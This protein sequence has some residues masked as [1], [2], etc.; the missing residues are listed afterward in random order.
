MMKDAA[1]K[2]VSVYQIDGMVSP[3]DTCTKI[4]HIG[5]MRWTWI[6]RRFAPLINETDVPAALPPA[7]T[8]TCLITLLCIFWMHTISYVF[9]TLGSFPDI[10]P[11]RAQEVYDKTNKYIYIITYIYLKSSWTI[12][13][14]NSLRGSKVY[15]LSVVYL[16]LQ[17]MPCCQ[18]LSGILPDVQSEE[19]NASQWEHVGQVEIRFDWV[20]GGQRMGASCF[21]K[22][23]QNDQHHGG[24]VG[25]IA[26]SKPHKQPC[27]IPLNALLQIF[28]N[29]CAMWD[30][31]TL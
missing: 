24:Y 18:C 31:K 3:A 28:Q 5:S 1:L 13:V 25:T 23:T 30:S 2:H 9:D 27:L 7:A 10:I 11:W 17:K 20:L 12:H 6:A 14:K 19:L 8:W 15:S 22:S 29:Y 4:E 26:G 16:A 21:G